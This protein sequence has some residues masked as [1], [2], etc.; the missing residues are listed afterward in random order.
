MCLL[1]RYLRV[2]I[3]SAEPETVLTKLIY[4][5]IEITDAVW[6]D[7]LT[8]EIQIHN[9]QAASARKI[10]DRCG[11]SWSLLRREGTLWSII[12]IWKRP[13]LLAGMILFL[14]LASVLQGRILF[15]RVIGNDGVSD[16]QILQTAESCGIRFAAKAADVRSE[17]VKNH[18]LAQLPRLQWLGVTTSGCVAT[19]HVKERSVAAAQPDNEHHVSSII[20][21]QDGMITQMNVYSG[22]PLFQTG[23][24]VK[25]GDVIISGYTDCGI[26]VLAGQADGE[27]FAHTLRDITFLS[28]SASGARG[29]FVKKHT[30]YR[31]RIGKKVINLCNHSGI[32]DATCVK[33]YSEDYWTLPGGFQLP[34]ALIKVTSAYYADS[35]QI[36]EEEDNTWLPQYARDYLLSQMI[37][38]E[39]L[40]ESLI[41]NMSGG[42]CEL[43]GVYACHEMIG[44]V[45]CEET[46][47]QYAEDN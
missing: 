45:K 1:D 36:G 17:N 3:T 29:D 41:C 32:Q 38:G 18:L 23:Q 21:A 15:I 22:N 46:I 24:T 27:V 31:L 28:P 2:R 42:V 11:A 26:K 30:C 14:V 47:E 7:P 37:A 43:N 8:V 33:M 25:A 39:I 40:N 10:L 6:L 5:D 13:V 19:I 12:N 16:T 9:R 44:Q 34:V 35:P 20:A 4:D